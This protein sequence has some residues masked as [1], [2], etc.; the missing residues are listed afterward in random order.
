VTAEQIIGLS[1]ARTRV[2]AISSAARST[3]RVAEGSV[4]S[5]A[6]WR[7]IPLLVLLATGCGQKPVRDNRGV[8]PPSGIQDKVLV[9]ASYSNA[10][11]EAE[12]DL[13][14]DEWKE[15]PW[16]FNY[17][18]FQ[19]ECTVARQMLEEITPELKRMSVTQLVR[20]LKVTSSFAPD[21]FVGV[22]GCLYE[23]GAAA[24]IAEIQ[25]RP[26]TELSVLPSLA[27]QWLHVWEGPQGPGDSLDTVIH[28]RIL[29]DR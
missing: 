20:S 12:R 6:I 4:E 9:K 14:T 22:A 10:V 8:L 25:S 26:R 2:G 1:L 19:R 16:R 17:S 28:Y 27:D 13:P 5:L 21:D 7:A 11:T 23:S 29:K 18:R 3:S 15:L 24:I